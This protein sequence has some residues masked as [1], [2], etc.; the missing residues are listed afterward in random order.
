MHTIDINELFYKVFNWYQIRKLSA[1]QSTLSRES[2][3]NSA[4]WLY[5]L[6]YVILIDF[7]DH[8]Y[9]E[10]HAQWAAS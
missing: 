4:P 10:I 9:E 1:W 6:P 8:E 2:Y 7:I 5:D 3:S